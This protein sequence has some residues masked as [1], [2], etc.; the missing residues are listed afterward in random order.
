VPPT[1]ETARAVV[2]HGPCDLRV[3]TIALPPLGPRDVLVRVRAAGICGSDLHFWK[4][5]V[6]GAGVVLGHEIAGEIVAT[7]GEV[8]GIAAGDLGAVHSA[9]P[10]GACDRCRAGL[11]YYCQQ[12]VALGTGRG[13]GG[14]SEYLVAPDRCFLPAPPGSDPAALAWSEPL[15]NGLR[16]V[17]PGSVHGAKTGLVIGAGPIGLA[18]LAAARRAGVERLL[19]VE[20][21]ER[22]RAAALALGAERVIHP[23]EED[24]DAAVRRDFAHGAEVVIEAVGRPE[25]IERATRLARPRGS[26]FL[27]GVCFDE[28]PMRPLRWMLRELTLRSSLGC[29]RE[30]QR[31]A[32]GMITRGELDPRPLVTRRVPLDDAPAAIEALVAGADEIK[33]VVEPGGA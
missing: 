21:R 31:A 24:V 25:T 5:G 19:V 9:A 27:M 12:G 3:E 28:I 14:L 23:E 7:G 11:G 13:I 10:C 17:A 8:E 16:C 33:V 6:Y 2:Q 30:D 29:D 32:L 1:F 18:C 20:G 22:R 15:A 26:V 4:H